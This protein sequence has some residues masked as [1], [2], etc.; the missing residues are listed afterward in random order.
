MWKIKLRM[1]FGNSNLIAMHV[2]ASGIRSIH[3]ICQRNKS[4]FTHKLKARTLS[5]SNS[6]VTSHSSVRHD[7]N[8]TQPKTCD[9]IQVRKHTKETIETLN[10]MQMQ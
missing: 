1:T 2:R 6:I 5:A 4:N 10:S 9:D 3:S 7:E 8:Y